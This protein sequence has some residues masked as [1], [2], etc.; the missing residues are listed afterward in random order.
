MGLKEAGQ[1]VV[2]LLRWSMLA[3]TTVGPGTVVTCSRAG[4]EQGL[5]LIWALVFATILAFTLQVG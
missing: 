5:A 2:S 4:A 1:E 3:A